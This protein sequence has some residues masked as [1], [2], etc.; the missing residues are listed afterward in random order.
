[1]YSE[2]SQ[3]VQYFTNQYYFHKSQEK[4]KQFQ[5][6]DF[7]KRQTVTF[8]FQH[9]FHIHLSI[10]PIYQGSTRELTAVIVASVVKAQRSGRFFATTLSRLEQTCIGGLVKQLSP[11]TGCISRVNGISAKFVRSQNMNNGTLFLIGCFQR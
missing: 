9:I 4:N 6:A 3:L 2:Y 7:F 5:Q 8:N 11:Y 10:Y 1:M